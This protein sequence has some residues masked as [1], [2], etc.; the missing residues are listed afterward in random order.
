MESVGFTQRYEAIVLVMLCL[1]CV[2]G[3]C[4]EPEEPDI[5]IPIVISVTLAAQEE[6]VRAVGGSRVQVQVILP[7]NADPH[8][9][10]P[11]A[12]QMV[13]ISKSDLYFRI[14]D[15]L[16]PFEDAVVS[17]LGGVSG[18]LRVVDMSQ[19]IEFITGAEGK[20]ADPHIWLSLQNSRIMLDTISDSLISVDPDG[21]EYYAAN[22]DEYLAKIESLDSEIERSYLDVRTRTFIVTHPAWGYFARDYGLSQVHIETGGKEATA[23]DLERIITI[24]RRENI[25]VIFAEPQF[26]TRG[27]EMIAREIGGRVE[28]LDPMA[29]DYLANMEEAGEKISRS[30]M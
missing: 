25:S 5:D 6:M 4:V 28:L 7:G 13:N 18:N 21:Q 24:A 19:G 16:L 26:S 15:G 11:Q 27:A 12:G 23:Q 22:R 20:G 3:G 10:E 29:P 1:S 8:T 9:F 14:G 17:R 30:M 2:S